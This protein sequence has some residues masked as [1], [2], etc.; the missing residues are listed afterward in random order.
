VLS[1]VEGLK[2]AAPD[3]SHLAM[4]LALVVLTVLSRR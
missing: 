2:V 1:A 4:P 3:L